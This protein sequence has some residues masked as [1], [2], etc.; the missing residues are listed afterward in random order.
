M[1]DTCISHYSR[2]LPEEVALL[3]QKLTVFEL[4]SGLVHPTCQRYDDDISMAQ[5]MGLVLD[6]QVRVSA[7]HSG[8]APRPGRMGMAPFQEKMRLRVTGRGQNWPASAIA[9]RLRWTGCR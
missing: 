1:S 5:D 9:R 3:C 8:F 2:I 7:L 6:A 4:S